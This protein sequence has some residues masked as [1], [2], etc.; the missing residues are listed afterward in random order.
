MRASRLAIVS[1]TALLS[2]AM[3]SFCSAFTVAPKSD[4]SIGSFAFNACSGACP[5]NMFA[6]LVESSDDGR[7][8]DSVTINLEQ[9]YKTAVGGSVWIHVS[10][11]THAIA[12][13]E[14][15]DDYSWST[16]VDSSV[17]DVSSMIYAS[18]SFDAN[19]SV[20]YNEI[21]T[22]TPFTFVLDPCIPL[23]QG[24][25][26]K[27]EGHVSN[28]SSALGVS[29]QAGNANEYSVAYLV[30]ESWWGSNAPMAWTF[31]GEVSMPLTE[32]PPIMGQIEY[33]IPNW[34]SSTQPLFGSTTTTTAEWCNTF[35]TTSTAWTAEFASW[36]AI[37]ICRVAVDLVYPS[38][39]SVQ[40]M[41]DTKD[42][43]LEKV[44]FGYFSV[45]S[46]TIGGFTSATD[47][48]GNLDLVVPMSG[49]YATPT[50]RIVDMDAIHNNAPL[51]TI[52]DLIRDISKLVMGVSLFAWIW[53]EVVSHRAIKD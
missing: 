45:V 1:M 35:Y 46:S 17:L 25:T 33:D 39:E 44:P 20:L 10:T 16:G 4:P 42:N 36:V 15:S 19:P 18:Q 47:T 41:L 53:Y 12:E 32:A 27:I 14:R 13:F 6:F 8:M 21:S 7:C 22:P 30:Q 29:F 11:S 2:M 23:N 37:G 31:A 40:Y 48:T 26:A 3:P 49:Q 51:M 50:V 38:Q 9:Y 52:L 43:L 24:E 34:A 28:G 5:S